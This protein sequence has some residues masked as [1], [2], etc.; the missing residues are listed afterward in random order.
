MKNLSSWHGRWTLSMVSMKTTQC[1][2]FKQPFLEK[3]VL[4]NERLHP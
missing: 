1:E 3:K 2:E 4:C